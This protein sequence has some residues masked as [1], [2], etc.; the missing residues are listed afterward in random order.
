M[1]D[2]VNWAFLIIDYLQNKQIAHNIYI[3]RGKS[4]IKENKEEYRD[5]RIYIWAR[6]STQG[7]K[8]IHAFNLAACELFGHLSMKST[9]MRIQLQDLQPLQET[10]VRGNVLLTR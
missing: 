6:K 5:V 1:D 8:D 10:A 2:F 9:C 3:T 7:A 4:N